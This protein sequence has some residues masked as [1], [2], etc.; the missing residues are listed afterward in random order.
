MKRSTPNYPRRWVYWPLMSSCGIFA[1]AW[2]MVTVEPREIKAYYPARIWQWWT[3]LRKQELLVALL[4][5]KL[6]LWFYSFMFR[7]SFCD[8]AL[9]WRKI[10]SVAP[11]ILPRSSNRKF[12][13][14]E[15][16]CSSHLKKYVF[17][18]E[19]FNKNFACISRQSMCVHIV[20]Q[21]NDIFMD[22]NKKIKIFHKTSYF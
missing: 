19:K 6:D 18:C 8:R 5:S 17:N 15:C 4:G 12:N 14:S 2:E 16:I 22:D 13:G 11:L 10:L 3:Y 9:L 20:S 1:S 7:V 21:K